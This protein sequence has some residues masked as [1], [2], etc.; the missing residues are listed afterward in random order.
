MIQQ[1]KT[2]IF[3]ASAVSQ[4]VFSEHFLYQ[5]NLC[6]VWQ[7]TKNIQSGN[8]LRLLSKQRFNV[9]SDF[10]LFIKRSLNSSSI[11]YPAILLYNFKEALNQKF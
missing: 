2:N 9:S 4:R 5:C 6:N 7:F 11:D 8:I 10:Y 3:A 1:I